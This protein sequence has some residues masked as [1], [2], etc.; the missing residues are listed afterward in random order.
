MPTQS[1][2]ARIRTRNIPSSDGRVKG[3]D[4]I[5]GVRR[6]LADLRSRGARIGFVPTMGFLHEG[7]LHLCDVARERSDVVVVSIF[8]NPLQFGEGEDLDRYPRDLSR[9]RELAEQR[10][11]DILFTP[12]AEEMYPVGGAAVRVT[13]PGLDQRLCGRYRPGHFEGVLTVVAKLF[14][15]VAPDVA[16]FG[17]KDLQQAALIRRMVGDLDMPLEVVVAPV[18]RDPDGLALSSRNVYLDEAERCSALALHRSLR[19]AQEAFTGGRTEP[20]ELR[21]AALAI[22]EGTSGVTTQYVEVVDVDTLETPARARRGDAVAVA[23]HVGA[24]RLI[25]NHL[26]Y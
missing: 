17:Q 20:A 5:G 23:A 3:A 1:D 16:V 9:D 19:A 6:I 14:N 15:I 7:H 8:V 24:T 21:S 10:G 11:V 26:L 25:D 13:A 18:V 2:Q 22:L 4:T 12:D